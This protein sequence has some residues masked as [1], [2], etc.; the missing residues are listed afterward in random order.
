M[1]DFSWRMVGHSEVAAA[2]HETSTD[3][4]PVFEHGVSIWHAS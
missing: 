4:L 3:G 1:M 2:R